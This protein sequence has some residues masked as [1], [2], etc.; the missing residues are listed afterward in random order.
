[1]TRA[2]VHYKNVNCPEPRWFR[3][4][5]NAVSTASNTVVI[6][7]LATGY[8]EDS[9]TILYVRVGISGLMSFIGALLS[10]SET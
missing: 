7:L 9:L 10:D 3:R 1:M 6:L 4:L 2:N 8:S 5:K